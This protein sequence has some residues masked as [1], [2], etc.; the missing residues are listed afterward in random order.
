MTLF[1]EGNDISLETFGE[2][3]SRFGIRVGSWIHIVSVNSDGTLIYQGNRSFGS[4]DIG[5]VNVNVPPGRMFANG[6]PFLS[7]Y[8]DGSP[9]VSVIGNDPRSFEYGKIKMVSPYLMKKES[10]AG[11]WIPAYG[12]DTSVPRVKSKRSV[13]VITPGNI[14]TLISEESGDIVVRSG[15][16]YGEIS[17]LPGFYLVD[18]LPFG[19]DIIVA[20]IYGATSYPNATISLDVFNGGRFTFWKNA[21]FV[22]ILRS[23]ESF[24]YFNSFSST[25][26]SPFQLVSVSAPSANFI[27]T[28]GSRVFVTSMVEYSGSIRQAVSSCAD[29]GQWDMMDGKIFPFSDFPS[30]GNQDVCSVSYDPVSSEPVAM[31]LTNSSLSV[32]IFDSVLSVWRNWRGFDVVCFDEYYPELPYNNFL[33]SSREGADIILNWFPGDVISVS[34]ACYEYVSVTESTYTYNGS[35]QVFDSYEDCIASVDNNY[36]YISRE[37]GT[38]VLGWIPG[39]IIEVSGSCYEYVGITDSPST[40]DGVDEVH[41][42]YDECIGGND[43]NYSF[44]Q[45]GGS[46]TVVMN[47]VPGPIVDI[48]GTCYEYNGITESP[49]EYT[50]CDNVYLSCDECDI[51]LGN[52]YLYSSREGDSIVLGWVPG[53]VVD[54]LG[55]CYEYVGITSSL[56]TRDGVDEVYESYDDCSDVESDSNHLFVECGGS[57]TVVMS[58]VPGPIVEFGISCYKYAGIT[59]LAVTNTSCDNVYRSCD[60][61]DG[62]PPDNNYL[63]TNIGGGGDVILPDVPGIVIKIGSL[64]YSY[65]GITS[66]PVTHSSPD[67]VYDDY[68]YCENSYLVCGRLS[69]EVIENVMVVVTEFGTT[70]VVTTTYTD[71]EGNYCVTVVN[72]NYVVTCEL[73]DPPVVFIPP[74]REVSVSGANVLGVNFSNVPESSSSS[75]QSSSSQSSSSSNPFTI[76]WPDDPPVLMGDP[77]F[78]YLSDA[79]AGDNSLAS[80]NIDDNAGTNA[81]YWFY[82]ERDSTGETF[83][84]IYTNQ[85]FALTVGG[86]S[87]DSITL[88]R[89]YPDPGDPLTTIY[90]TT[91]YTM[92][93]SQATCYKTVNG[94]KY[95][96]NGPDSISFGGV[97][98]SISKRTLKGNTQCIGDRRYFSLFEMT[99]LTT[100][101]MQTMSAFGGALWYIWKKLSTEGPG[102]VNN[103]S[104]AGID[105]IQLYTGIARTSFEGDPLSETFAQDYSDPDVT[106]IPSL[107][108]LSNIASK[109]S[110]LLTITG[111]W[112]ANWDPLVEYG[113][114]C[115]L[116]CSTPQ[117]ECSVT[118]NSSAWSALTSYSLGDIVRRVVPQLWASSTAYSIGDIVKDPATLLYHQCVV[119][120]TSGTTPPNWTGVLGDPTDDG[121]VCWV[122]VLLT[123]G[124]RYECTVAGTSSSSEPSWNNSIGATTSDGTVT[125]RRVSNVISFAGEDWVIPTD[126]GVTRDICGGYTLEKGSYQPSTTAYP[127]YMVGPNKE[128]DKTWLAIEQ[129]NVGNLYLRQAV[130]TVKIVRWNQ[131]PN[132]SPVGATPVST[133]Y[134]RT[135]NYGLGRYNRANLKVAGEYDE[136]PWFAAN[137]PTRPP[138]GIGVTYTFVSPY[139]QNDIGKI[140]G[141]TAP[142]YDNY[143]LSSSF[144]GSHSTNGLIYSWDKKLGTGW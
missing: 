33:Y 85:E 21:P 76:D 97:E 11:D 8:D 88:K 19:D 53:I 67:A 110:E 54:V 79:A 115:P 117:M 6:I 129:W 12:E 45:C 16:G 70:T 78:Y 82:S 127:Y 139:I 59:A 130:W 25:N 83:E 20:G 81:M 119:P 140:I 102:A 38:V 18:A 30:L 52:N 118:D 22:F 44:T 86:K 75:S 58:F 120:G 41:L 5:Y 111:N 65:I 60:E 26:Q 103:P 2:G 131:N 1:C 137:I 62:T 46:A 109:I 14:M 128:L 125:W 99:I 136:Q 61:C 34:G 132:Y 13:P 143:R 37:G 134:S 50:S 68:E 124:E 31:Y 141:I 29:G 27:D 96:F 77:H 122:A 74:E 4:E 17:R 43:N 135:W 10:P 90:D 63:Y 23:S 80:F 142:K 36:L 116:D 108:T 93:S 28:D 144:F 105:G 56:I 84:V 101:N 133:Y 32:R 89:G 49:V 7:E 39:Q 9:I 87:M 126:S 24:A 66:S 113:P 42:S 94:V 91:E 71:S 40:R 121:T 92:S 138:S 123:A 15:S 72:G 98:I 48:E 100:D 112:T 35:Y 51:P 104:Y 55:V 69:G 47:F 114:F 64:C 107:I 3:V 57:A 73:D 95:G 106:G